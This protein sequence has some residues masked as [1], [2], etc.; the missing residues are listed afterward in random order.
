MLK[1]E[2]AFQRPISRE[3]GISIA[4]VRADQ[5]VVQIALWIAVGED[6]A[7]ARL[8]QHI[9]RDS[10]NEEA[11]VFYGVEPF[12]LDAQNAHVPTADTSR[13]LGANFQIDGLSVVAQSDTARV[14][15]NTVSFK[16]AE[17]KYV[18]VLQEEIA[19]LREEQREASQIDLSIV[20]LG[21]GEVR[22]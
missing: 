1:P 10:T 11:A 9:G 7:D 5:R 4:E 18:D 3:T 6:H 22:V 8:L 13:D 15:R 12:L 20:D 16:P 21:R 17:R 2:L 14:E 19:F